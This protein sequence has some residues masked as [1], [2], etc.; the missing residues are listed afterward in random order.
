MAEIDTGPADTGAARSAPA[1]PDP[2]QGVKDAAL[3]EMAKSEDISAYAQEREARDQEAKGE[4]VDTEQRAERIRKALTEARAATQQARQENGLDQ[5]EPDLDTAYQDATRVWAE[6]EA[7]EQQRQQEIEHTRKTAVDEGRFMAVAEQ[8]KQ[9]N[10]QVWNQ[11]SETM[12]AADFML[13]EDQV[14]A[15]K[16]GLTKGGGSEG[17]AIAYRLSQPTTNADGTV[18]SPEAKIQYLAS[19]P[20]AQLEATLDQAR[21]YLELETRI[22]R[23]YAAAYAAQGRRHTQAPPPFKAPRGG[24][25]PPRSLEA[26]ASKGESIKDYV[27]ARKVQMKRGQE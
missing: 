10:P 24:A 17:M 6:Q 18:I 12:Q 25:A 23:Q 8:L 1:A 15:F 13:K 26:L 5:T 3:T 27:N 7:A 21:Q 2:V 14:D 16:R 22:G 20:P 11:V 19:L 9:A 4:E